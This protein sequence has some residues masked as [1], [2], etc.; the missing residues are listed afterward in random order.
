VFERIA[1]LRDC[2]APP[3]EH[4]AGKGTT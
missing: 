4:I 2:V 3:Q 1:K